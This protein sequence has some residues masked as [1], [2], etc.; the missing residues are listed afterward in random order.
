MFIKDGRGLGQMGENTYARRGRGCVTSVHMRTRGEGKVKFSLIW[1]IGTNCIIRAL[2]I[3]SQLDLHVC[4]LLLESH[5]PN[6]IHRL[7]RTVNKE[8]YQKQVQWP[9]VGELRMVKVALFDTFLVVLA[10]TNITFNTF[11]IYTGSLIVY[12]AEG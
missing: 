2:D 10:F 7:G 11:R 3:T 5:L 4:F 1:S 8:E 9:G 6:Q 12:C